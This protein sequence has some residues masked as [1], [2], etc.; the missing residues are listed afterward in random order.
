MATP[1]QTFLYPVT[2]HGSEVLSIINPAL[3]RIFLGTEEIGPILKEAN[4]QI[5]ALY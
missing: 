2:Y 4:D 5:K 1:D 3:D